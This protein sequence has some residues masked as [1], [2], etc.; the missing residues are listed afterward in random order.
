MS[1][2]YRHVLTSGIEA[3]R[4]VEAAKKSGSSSISSNCSSSSSSS[5]SSSIKGDHIVLW[6]V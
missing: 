4:K 3:G 2:S 5:S 6:C 1:S